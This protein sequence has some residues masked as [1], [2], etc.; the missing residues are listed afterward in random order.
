MVIKLP[1]NAKIVKYQWNMK[2]LTTDISL[3][4]FFS[5]WKLSSLSPPLPFPS[6]LHFPSLPFPPGVWA[7]HRLWLRRSLTV[8]RRQTKLLSLH[9]NDAFLGDFES[10][11]FT[12]VLTRAASSDELVAFVKVAFWLVTWQCLQVKAQFSFVQSPHSP[13]Q[14][15]FPAAA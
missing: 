3:H 5:D 10:D 2:I 6:P 14:L 15:H 8:N 11:L 13:C 7:A 9:G 4:T 12:V 1:V